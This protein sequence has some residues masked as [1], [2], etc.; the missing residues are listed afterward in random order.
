[1]AMTPPRLVETSVITSENDLDLHL[2]DETDRGVLPVMAVVVV[3]V[4]KTVSSELALGV[5]ECSALMDL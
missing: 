4:D 1:M 2:L 3:V 5:C